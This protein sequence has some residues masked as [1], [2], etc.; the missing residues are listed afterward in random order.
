VIEIYES[1]IENGVLD[2]ERGI[3]AMETARDQ[4]QAVS[5]TLFE[6]MMLNIKEPV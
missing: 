1:A 3:E 6:Q 2:L 4:V 5:D